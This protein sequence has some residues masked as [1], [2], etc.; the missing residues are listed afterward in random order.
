LKDNGIKATFYSG[1]TDGAVP[2]YG[3]KQWIAELGFPTIST[4]KWREWMTDGQVSGF[5]ENYEGLDFVTFR[6]VGHMAPQ[7]NP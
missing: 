3:S 6:G 7:W 5:V 4:G 1:D 2:T